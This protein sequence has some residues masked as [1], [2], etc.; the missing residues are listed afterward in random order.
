MSDEWDEAERVTKRHASGKFGKLDDGSSCT[1][2]WFGGPLALEQHWTTTGSVPC[3]GEGCA[4][5]R[6]GLPIKAR[7]RINYFDLTDNVMRIWEGG[8]PFLRDLKVLKKKFSFADMS[9][10]ITRTGTG[11]NTKY[12]I[13]PDKPLT[14]EQKARIAKALPHNLSE[15]DDGDG[16]G[17]DDST[18]GAESEARTATSNTAP[19]SSA[20]RDEFIARL[21]A[22]RSEDALFT[23]L[24]TF[25]CERISD[26]LASDEQRARHLLET[27]ERK[28]PEIN[29]F[30]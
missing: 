20:V 12:L 5:C 16:Y 18:A 26:V 7:V 10:E 15:Q 9:F 30:S 1:V 8:P 24:G 25:H 19:I 13:L 17:E 21:Q 14:A 2:A 4:L 22:L 29:P 28:K 11:K 23:F 6:K 27:L 3:P